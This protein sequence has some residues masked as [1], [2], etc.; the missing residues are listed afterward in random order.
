[1]SFAQLEG[2]SFRAGLRRHLGLDVS[3]VLMG[4]GCEIRF[5]RLALICIYANEYPITLLFKYCLILQ[6]TEPGS[7]ADHSVSKKKKRLT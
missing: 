7:R 2:V 4:H 5:Q 3:F 6:A 1:M